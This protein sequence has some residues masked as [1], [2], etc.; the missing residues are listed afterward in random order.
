MIFSIWSIKRHYLLRVNNLVYTRWL[1]QIIAQAR[2][3]L[4]YHLAVKLFSMWGILPWV[5][6]VCLVLLH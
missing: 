6:V 1:H 2:P 4:N 5:F 3:I